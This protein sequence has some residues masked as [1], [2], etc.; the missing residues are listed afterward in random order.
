MVKKTLT[1]DQGIPVTDNRNYL[2]AGQLEMMV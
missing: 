2:T 1:D